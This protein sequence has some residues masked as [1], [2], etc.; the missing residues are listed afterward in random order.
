MKQ[1][2]SLAEEKIERYKKEIELSRS[3]TLSCKNE[4][5]NFKQEWDNFIE[6][7]D[8]TLINRTY[9]FQQES[10][11]LAEDNN[12]C[13][14][15]SNQSQI[16]YLEPNAT[17]I[18]SL[19]RNIDDA[20]EIDTCSGI[21]TRFGFLTSK[22]CCQADELSLYDLNNSKDIPLD[23]N[24]LWLEDSICLI[25]KIEEIEFISSI[26]D[27]E[28]YRL[29]SLSMYD[30]ENERFNKQT[31]KF[32]II[33]CFDS[34]CQIKIDSKLYQNQIILNGTLIVC[35]NSA[36][37]AIVTKSKYSLIKSIHSKLIKRSNQFKLILKMTPNL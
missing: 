17:I 32:K 23:E 3:E 20:S 11:R 25:N 36:Q 34:P 4:I 24:S 19:I 33:G 31:L 37:S 9:D 14:C 16:H 18:I 10:E 22:L 29:C 5:E 21:L 15:S 28:T 13:S 26:T 7:L 30:Y 12:F 2:L 1:K 8:Q 35:E 27:N 6:G